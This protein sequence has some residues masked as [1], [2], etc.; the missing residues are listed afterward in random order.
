MKKQ[1]IYYCPICGYELED[2]FGSGELCPCCFREAGYDDEIYYSE[3]E[4]KDLLKQNIYKKLDISE[5]IKII[6]DY[7]IKK[8]LEE[9]VP[10]KMIWAYLRAVWIKG[11]S[12]YTWDIIKNIDDD[13]Y[14]DPKVYD[15]VDEPDWTKEK[16]YLQL[17]RIGIDARKFIKSI[18]GEE[19]E[20]YKE[21]I[22]IMK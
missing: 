14:K 17:K 10:E 20:L 5:V 9:D 22:E 2:Y 7:E 4:T 11:G 1:E 21:A 18:W 19:S 15:V 16:A 8:N 3:L 6:P 13:D 12:Y